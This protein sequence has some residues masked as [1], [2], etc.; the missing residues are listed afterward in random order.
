ML[1]LSAG[2]PVHTIALDGFILSQLNQLQLT[3][4]NAVFDSLMQTVDSEVLQQLQLF[5][6]H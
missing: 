5:L 1:Q 2:D 4:G 3:L 6:R